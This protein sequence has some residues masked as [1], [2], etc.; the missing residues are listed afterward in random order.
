MT[1]N[2][3]VTRAKFVPSFGLVVQHADGLIIFVNADGEETPLRAADSK[4][5]DHD[6][7]IAKALFGEEPDP[8]SV[9]L[10]C[11]C[12]A[13]FDENGVA[14]GDPDKHQVWIAWWL[15]RVCAHLATRGT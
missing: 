13:M 1:D 5:A 6:G 10:L 9:A 7:L 8:S 4:T 3:R 2:P 14:A 11:E 12:A 15:G